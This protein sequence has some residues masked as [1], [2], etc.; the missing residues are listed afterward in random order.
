MYDAVTNM[1]ADLQRLTRLLG[2]DA[3]FYVLALHS[4]VEHYIRDVLE[5]SDAER[6]SDLVWEYRDQLMEEAGGGFVQ[7]LNCL[8]SLGRQHKYTNGVRHSFREMGRQEAVAATHHFVV[9]CRL[10]GLG[11]RPEI[12][13][14]KRNLDCWDDH[15]TV[16]EQRSTMTAIHSELARVQ[17]RNRELL[18]QVDQFQSHSGEL[19][20]VEQKIANLTLEL[21]QARGRVKAKDERVDQLRHERAKLREEKKR[22]KVRIAEYSD[23][24]RYIENLG[25]SSLYT[26]TRMD[27]ERTL[28]R[29]TPE[30]SDAVAA[31]DGDADFLIRG[32]AGTGK[33]LVLIEALRR[34]LEAGELD[35]DADHGQGVM[36]L[37]FTRTLARFE[38][39]LTSVLDM[40]KVRKLVQTVDAF[41][42][43]RL[44]MIDSDFGFDFQAMNRMAAELNTTGFLTDV[45]LATEVEEYL[46]ANVITQGEYVDEM[47]P[48]VGLRRRLS[49]A[50]RNAV[51]AIRDQM[52]QKMDES[53]QFSRNYARIRIL[54]FLA[55]ASEGEIS[56]LRDTRTIYL[57]ETQDLRSGDLRTLKSLVTGHLIMAADAEQ[58]IYGVASPYARAGIAVGGRTRVLKTDF[59]NTR[60]IHELA[61][62]FRPSEENDIFAFRDGPPPELYTD[63]NAKTLLNT[64]IKKL[65][66]FL[67]QL[68][69]DAENIAILTPHNTELDNVALALSER[70]I[71]A[72]IIS[73]REFRFSQSGGVRLTTLHSSKGL[74]F[75]VV[76]MYLPYLQRREM[77]DEEVTERLLRNLIYVG[78]TR[79]MESLNVFANPGRDPVLEDL[80]S[81]FP[82]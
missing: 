6:F 14:L 38:D 21:D 18:Q 67:H 46:F 45:E 8:S 49:R 43:K 33:S 69:Y 71:G 72:Q 48:R 53:R 26:Q 55:I 37:T 78:I 3:G 9:F 7:G 42:L 10:V 63:T 22:L 39:Y 23:L 13:D 32:S 47:I 2:S 41:L 52:V 76:L 34:A 5:A 1:D 15:Q 77:Y 27:Y 62:R 16:I 59:R 29:L 61:S 19:A 35:F 65:D 73:T 12:L 54:E 81:A 44:K 4:F 80:V 25:R 11:D 24:E 74:D 70:G 51:W 64:L 30:Q 58:T 66:L 31:M 28:L 17:N 40:E 36:L 56:K 79:A 57:D 20:T 82:V 68:E 75:P 60:Q 50:Q